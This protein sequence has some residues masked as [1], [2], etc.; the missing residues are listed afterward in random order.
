MSA[1]KDETKRNPTFNTDFVAP[2]VILPQLIL[3]SIPDMLWIMTNDLL[4]LNASK[5]WLD[6]SGRTLAQEQGTGWQESIH[7]SDKER[8][9]TACA[10]TTPDSSLFSVTYRILAKTGTY[11][12]VTTQARQ[13]IQGNNILGYVAVIH[14]INEQTESDE[15]HRQQQE[16]FWTVAETTDT[17]IIITNQQGNITSMNTAASRLLRIPSKEALGEQL[18]AIIADALLA[19]DGTP[20]KEEENPFLIATK[21]EC[22]SIGKELG[23]KHKDETITWC[24]TS[25]VPLKD[26]LT[27]TTTSIITTFNNVTPWRIAKEAEYAANHD[28]LTGLENRAGLLK[29]LE[30]S[31]KRKEREGTDIGVLFCDLD[32]FKNINDTYGHHAG[33]RVLQIVAERMQGNVRGDDIVSRLGGDEM[34]IILNG[35]RG[36]QGATKVAQTIIND[37]QNPIHIGHAMVSITVSIGI[38][39]VGKGEDADKAIQRADKAMYKAKKSGRNRISYSVPPKEAKL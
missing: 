17:A 13:I 30:S 12:W 32:Y 23:V 7:P 9:T 20:V 27:G 28:P 11:R 10:E 1:K 26:A 15:R 14:D 31:I 37:L 24:V 25:S 5:Q 8:I 6:W 18:P 21:K 36:K 35:T 38:T 22:P 34:V 16:M 29:K 3:D 4:L 2:E 33:D 39:L 19:E